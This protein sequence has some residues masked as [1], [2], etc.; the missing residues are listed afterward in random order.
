MTLSPWQPE[1]V[2]QTSALALV[3]RLRPMTGSVLEVVIDASKAPKRG[4]TIQGARW[5]YDPTV[6]HMVWAH[7]FLLAGLHI[8]GVLIP[9]AVRLCVTKEFCLSSEGKRLG[10]SY[11]NLNELAAE[12]LL[13]LPSSLTERFQVCV[14][15]DAGFLNATVVSACQLL[16]FT[17]VSV[18]KA[19][20]TFFPEHYRGKRH[21]GDYAPGVLRYEGTVIRLGEKKRQKRYRIAERIGRMK[22]LGCVK[23]VFSQRLSDRH[24]LTLVT[25]DFSLS[26]R[27][28]VLA[29]TGRWEI[30]VLIKQLKGQLGLGDYQTRGYEGAVAHLHLTCLAHHLLLHLWLVARAESGTTTD[31]L[32]PASVGQLQDLLRLAVW[33]DHLDTLRESAEGQALIEKLRGII[34]FPDPHQ[35]PLPFPSLSSTRK[36]NPLSAYR[37]AA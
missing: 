29:Y 11:K 8:K 19:N 13:G 36:K 3:E 24:I 17:W 32:T 28:V 34:R 9:W 30:E 12:V 37:M 18:A 7:Q 2:L 15:M 14:L 10:L 35:L 4:K 33:N 16:G 25:N 5:V 26:A 23:V 6:G 22:K 21:V 20:R 1:R 27:E 31:L